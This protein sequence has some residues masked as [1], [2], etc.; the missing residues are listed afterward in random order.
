MYLDL[1]VDLFSMLTSA[2]VA[3]WPVTAAL[4]AGQQSRA[5]GCCFVALPGLAHDPWRRLEIS[6]STWS[7]GHASTSSPPP[8]EKE[9]SRERSWDGR[10]SGDQHGGGHGGGDRAERHTWRVVEISW[11]RPK[12]EAAWAVVGGAPAYSSP[13]LLSA[14]W[15]MK[16]WRLHA[17]APRRR[18][19][20]KGR[21]G[22]RWLEREEWKWTGVYLAARVSILATPWMIGMR[23]RGVFVV[24][25]TGIKIYWCFSFPEAWHNEKVGWCLRITARS[26]GSSNRN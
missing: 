3:P 14:G 16:E 18:G 5:R 22:R 24:L 23:Y 19:A 7:Q 4:A 11:S 26:C 10:E 8:A 21:E 25:S 12:G 1:D 20:K 2:V 13:S 17:G 15:R 6:R 9:R